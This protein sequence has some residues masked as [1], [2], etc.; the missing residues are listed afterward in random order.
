[1]IKCSWTKAASQHLPGVEARDGISKSDRTT[2]LGRFGGAG[3]PSGI[4]GRS[5]LLLADDVNSC[6]EPSTA[7]R[8]SVA[9]FFNPSFLDVADFGFG[10]IT[11]L[12]MEKSGFI[13]VTGTGGKICD[14]ESGCCCWGLELIDPKFGRITLWVDVEIPAITEL[15]CSF[16]ADVLD[17]RSIITFFTWGAKDGLTGFEVWV[18]GNNPRAGVFAVIDGLK[19]G[20]NGRV[21]T[22][23]VAY[24]RSKFQFLSYFNGCKF[25]LLN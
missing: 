7:F 1:M 24:T 4:I 8:F 21:A 10:V 14:G 17:A 3:A 12:G 11:G 20:I 6:E 25:N 13:K 19:H 15:D 16:E 23:G 18:I 22:E 5:Q 9:G 2:A